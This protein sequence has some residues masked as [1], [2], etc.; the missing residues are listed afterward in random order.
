MKTK[1]VAI[2]GVQFITM[3]EVKNLLGFSTPTIR[4]LMF[5]GKLPFYRVGAR[6]YFR[7]IDIYEYFLSKKVS[8]RKLDSINAQKEL[9][10]INQNK[11]LQD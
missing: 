9:K 7:E 10:T 5:K 1:S 2:N 3:K 6:A 8:K 4:N 11:E